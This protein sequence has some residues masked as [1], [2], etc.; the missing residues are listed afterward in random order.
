MMSFVYLNW[1][2]ERKVKGEKE[3]V[4]YIKILQWSVDFAD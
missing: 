4:L 3:E 2:E 1:M